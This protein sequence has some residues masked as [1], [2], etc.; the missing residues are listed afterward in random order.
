MGH[1]RA[2]QPHVAD[3]PAP[4]PA[5]ATVPVLPFH[6][7]ALDSNASCW[8]PARA[9]FTSLRMDRGRVQADGSCWVSRGLIRARSRRPGP[10]LNPARPIANT[11]NPYRLSRPI[12]PVHHLGV[13][14]GQ[15]NNTPKIGARPDLE[16]LQ[17]ESQRNA[18]GEGIF[19]FPRAMDSAPQQQY[20]GSGNRVSCEETKKPGLPMVKAHVTGAGAAFRPT[21][22]GGNGSAHPAES[23]ATTTAA[24]E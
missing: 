8:P 6:R 12:S 18:K 1:I 16:H 21:Q 13:T 3:S 4:I 9:A 15:S 17:E 5:V 20:S 24:N 11:S 10:L 19:S 22:L 2:P 23:S 7:L 14:S